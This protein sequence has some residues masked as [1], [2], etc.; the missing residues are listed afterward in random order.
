M[1]HNGIRL[2]TASL[3][4]GERVLFVEGVPVRRLRCGDCSARFSIQPEG[5]TSRRHHQPCVVARAVATIGFDPSAKIAHVASAHGCHRRTLGRWIARVAAI[6]DPA[7]LS[8]ALVAEATSPTL[9][10][11]AIARTSRSA[12]LSAA[13]SRAAAVLALL[14]ALASLRGL[15]PPAL[16]HAADLVPAVARPG[17]AGGGASSGV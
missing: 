10:K 12:R 2:R 5:L 3:F 8:R 14:E 13:V 6:A 7:A 16:A 4:D 9:P 1:W 15:D 17:S 11:P